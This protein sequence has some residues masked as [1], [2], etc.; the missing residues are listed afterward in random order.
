MLTL[1]NI[2]WKLFSFVVC[3]VPLQTKIEEL[4]NFFIKKL[5]E[6]YHGPF[7]FVE[8]F[9]FGI[10]FLIS[11]I[12]NE[13]G[14][15]YHVKKKLLYLTLNFDETRKLKR[16]K[17]R[18]IY[19]NIFLSFINIYVEKMRNKKLSGEI[20]KNKIYFCLQ[21]SNF[22][23]KLFSEKYSVVS[24]DCTRA[25]INLNPL[26]KRFSPNSVAKSPKYRVL[27]LNA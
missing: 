16:K 20:Y 12:K 23:G 11:V 14:V 9:N 3:L 5:S 22:Y 4:W 1:E 8:A 10:L 6:A 7:S 21:S 19:S 17:K 24:K 18:S 15:G 13:K 25:R 2:E 26:T 27:L